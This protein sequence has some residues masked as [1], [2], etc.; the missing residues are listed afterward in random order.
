MWHWACAAA[1]ADTDAGREFQDYMHSLELQAKDEGE[2]PLSEFGRGAFAEGVCKS[3]NM[4]EK[5]RYAEAAD[6]LEALVTDAI[7][8]DWRE[9][10]T[11]RIE[12]LRKWAGTGRVELDDYHAF[13]V[14]IGP[15]WFRKRIPP[16]VNAFEKLDVPQVEK[17]FLIGELFRKRGDTKGYILALSTIPVL[18]EVD[19]QSATQALLAAGSAY[20]ES[21]NTRM[22]E[23]YWRE[24]RKHPVAKS[25]WTKAVFNLGTLHEERKEYQK[26]IDYFTE[27]LVSKP[28]D[29]EPGASL[30]D[31]CRNYS[32]R[33][34]LEISR[35]YENMSN[36]HESLRYAWLAKN[37]YRYVSWCGT[38]RSSANWAL[39]KRI[40]YLA[41][42]AYG[43]WVV[44]VA[45][46]ILAVRFYRKKRKTSEQRAGA[47]GKD[48][49]AQP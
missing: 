27:V 46:A 7:A 12:I 40:A 6:I 17:H 44:V 49:A 34:A 22:A 42:R 5:G 3:Q 39:N 26:A 15:E 29:G 32:H 21:G 43:F 47:D 37:R 20:H 41:T 8:P 9:M 13:Y 28:D 45:L 16:I 31:T 18:Q 23:E 35:S 4:A 33:S 36:Y 48:H 25:A 24:A 30:M 38:C 11:V 19:E 14:E 1:L 10:L 2:I